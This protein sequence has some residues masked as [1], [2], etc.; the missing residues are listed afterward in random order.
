MNSTSQ[1]HHDL[2]RE[3]GPRLVLMARQWVSCHA[4]AEDVV[5]SAFVRYWNRRDAAQDPVAYLYR[6]L[7]NTAMNHRRSES[8]RQRH[9]QASAEQLPR[10]EAMFVSPPE[11]AEREELG[12]QVTRALSTL[13]IEQREVI[14]MRTWA[15]LSFDTIGEVM[16]IP[17]RTA[18][19][20]YRYG[21]QALRKAMNATGV[22]TA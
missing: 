22:S 21:I 16:E 11:H 6:T 14:V 19:S 1:A 3:H 5:Q 7:R 18:Q 17:A 4:D 8:R 13:P 10:H 9:E 12:E 15:Q 20:R 2:L